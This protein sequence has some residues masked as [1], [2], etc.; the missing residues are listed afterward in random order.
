MEKRVPYKP[1]FLAMAR[2]WSDIEQHYIECFQG[3]HTN[4]L[5][6][7]RHI[8]TSDLSERLFAYTSMDKLVISIYDRIDTFV[9]ALHI[10]FDIENAKWHFEYYA[11]PFKDPEFVRTCSADK[12][13][14]KFDNFIKMIKW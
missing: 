9:E 3:Q 4:L 11:H 8:Q 12:G 13:I 1:P 14:E 7:V 6:L 10:N 5:E 2:P